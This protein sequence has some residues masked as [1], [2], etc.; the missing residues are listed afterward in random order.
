MGSHIHIWWSRLAI[1]AWWFLFVGIV[2]SVTT[3]PRVF[4]GRPPD[5]WGNLAWH[6]GWLTWCGLTFF[7]IWLARRFP[8]ERKRLKRNGIIQFFL[9]FAVVAL[10]VGI[11]FGLFYSLPLLNEDRLKN[12]LN[13]L[14]SLVA[15]K[16]HIN[17]VIYW[18]IVGATNAYDYYVKFRNSEVA[19]SQLEAK[20]AQSEL[21]ALKMQLHPHFLFNTHHSIISLML[22]EK[23]EEAI[24]MLTQLSDLL[25]ATLEKSN[26]QLSSLKDELETLDLYLDIQKVRFEERLRVSKNIDSNLLSAEVPF[27]ILQPLVENALQYG[28]DPLQKGGQ[29]G[30]SATREGDRLVLSVV[31]NGPGFSSENANTKRG[32]VG[33]ATTRS[34]LEQLYGANHSFSIE[35]TQGKGA[36]VVISLPFKVASPQS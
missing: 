2:A 19:S 22:K 5:F 17:L 35:S 33:I 16:F 8:L 1:V 7:A 29:L 23:N 18:A 25:R 28:V 4:T 9:G 6:S 10:N 13:F 34:R 3:L 11:E 36:S 15:Y 32:G 27:L 12:P 31:D 24:R 26:Q 21:Q 20:L 30:I 14:G